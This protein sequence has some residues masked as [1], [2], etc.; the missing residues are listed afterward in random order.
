MSDEFKMLGDAYDKMYQLDELFPGALEGAGAALAGPIGAGAA[1][2]ITGKKDRK[3]K[4]AI[5]SGTGAAV[6]GALGGPLGAV[7]GGGLGGAVSEG[8]DMSGAPNVGKPKP[9]GQKTDVKYDKKMGVMAP[10]V[11]GVKEQAEAAYEAWIAEGDFA[12]MGKI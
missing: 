11:K 5:G 8:N 12:N 9:T 4:K 3:M 7:I 6:G 10:N 1:G 2:A